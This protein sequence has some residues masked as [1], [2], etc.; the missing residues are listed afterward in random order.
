VRS[1]PQ[2]HGRGLR[3]GEAALVRALAR[4]SALLPLGDT[5][6][7]QAARRLAAPGGEI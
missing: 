7:V 1:L 5:P 3:L 4:S 2:L 6:P